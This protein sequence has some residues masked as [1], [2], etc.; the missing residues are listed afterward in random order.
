MFSRGSPFG[1]KVPAGRQEERRS[2]A[3]DYLGE[4]RSAHSARHQGH[5]VRVLRKLLSSE[6]YRVERE[7]TGDFRLFIFPLFYFIKKY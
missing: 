5:F 3:S 4:K 2:R 6:S 7:R 1:R